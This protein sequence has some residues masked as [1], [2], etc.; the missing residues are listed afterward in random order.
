MEHANEQNVAFL[1][2]GD[3]FGATTHS[4]LYLRAVRRGITVT[5]IHNASIINAVGSCGLQL[6]SFGP[7]VTIPLFTA[8]WRPD[9]PYTKIARNWKAGLHTLCLLDI[10]VKE[11]SEENLL[12]GRLIYEPPRFMTVPQ[13]VRQLHE[14]EE[15][16]GEGVCS[17]E[18]LAVAMLRIGGGPRQTIITGTLG[19]LREA[20]EEI[21]GE[22][23]HSL[24]LPAKELH[25]LEYEMLQLNAISGSILKHMPYAEYLSRA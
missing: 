8:T 22:P 15:R 5:V 16:R 17:A 19:E 18:R 10:K 4:D 6:Y 9:S 23:L 11:V 25:E 7:I 12:R 20:S 14:L 13:A 21:F 2:V 24:I 3:P 1:V